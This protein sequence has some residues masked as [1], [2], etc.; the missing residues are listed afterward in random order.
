MQNFKIYACFTKSQD[1]HHIDKLHLIASIMLVREDLDFM[2]LDKDSTRGKKKFVVEISDTGDEFD[3]SK[4]NYLKPS[5]TLDTVAPGRLG[6]KGIIRHF[7]KPNMN[8][9]NIKFSNFITLIKSNENSNFF[10][11]LFNLED[12]FE[13]HKPLTQPIYKQL[14]KEKTFN[15]S[16]E[17]TIN[18]I[19]PLQL[20]VATQ[21]E[22][23][24]EDNTEKWT[25]IKKYLAKS[26]SS[27][28]SHALNK[29]LDT[30]LNVESRLSYAQDYSWNR[31][32]N[33]NSSASRP[34]ALS[35]KAQ[36][37]HAHHPSV[38]E[39]DKIYNQCLFVFNNITWSNI[40]LKFKINNIEISGGSSPSRHM[41][42][43]SDILLNYYLS[44]LTKFDTNYLMKIGYN[45]YK[46]EKHI[47]SGQIP[48]NLYKEYE[49]KIDDIYRSNKDKIYKL[50]QS[51]SGNLENK[52]A[53]TK[54][55]DIFY[56]PDYTGI[57]EFLKSEIDSKKEAINIVVNNLLISRQ[58][59]I[60]SMA[61]Y[62]ENKLLKTH[63]DN[64]NAINNNHWKDSMKLD[65]FSST[66]HTPN[67]EKKKMKK[68]R[69]ELLDQGLDAASLKERIEGYDSNLQSI[70]YIISER[71]KDLEQQINNWKKLSFG[72][73]FKQYEKIKSKLNYDT[74]ERSLLTNSKTEKDQNLIYSNKLRGL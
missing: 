31:R 22:I 71:K 24:T 57:D 72:E 23:N 66:K 53:L 9:I 13:D 11:Y 65:C 44:I 39:D 16:R 4:I 64:L 42:T 34:Q 21:E 63:K 25:I 10:R 58:I 5:N 28:S 49:N 56:G 51:L 2:L 38:G 74:Y 52:E 48:I 32:E 7:Q 37:S 8:Y 12:T 20:Q 29:S 40:V 14:D 3:D 17:K 67:K 73:L 62:L 50:I 18:D 33:L 54:F 55:S 41:L 60:R 59:I 27:F 69:R 1:E 68:K 6:D 46:N 36:A 45:S 15:K 26:S 19:K 30:D 35:F 43:T 70:E 47:L 61:L